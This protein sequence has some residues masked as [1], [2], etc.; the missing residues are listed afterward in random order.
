M[1]WSETD[2]E[3]VWRKANCGD[4]PLGLPDDLTLE[5]CQVFAAYDDGQDESS[6]F[7]FVRLSDG[8]YLVVRE[9]SDYTGHGCGCDGSASLHQTYEDAWM[10]GLTDGERAVATEFGVPAS[11]NA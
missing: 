3:E 4:H 2:V 11:S 9:S 5:G 7:A 8:Q 6:S 10:M 1:T